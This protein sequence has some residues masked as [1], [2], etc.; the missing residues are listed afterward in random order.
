M[1]KVEERKGKEGAA[2]A[3]LSA[4]KLFT[5]ENFTIKGYGVIFFNI[6]VSPLFERAELS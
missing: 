3:A 6:Y 5:T 4:D 1:M 2:A